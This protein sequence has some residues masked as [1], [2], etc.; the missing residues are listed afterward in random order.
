MGALGTGVSNLIDISKR[1]DPNG[2]VA[3]IIEMLSQV[4]SVMTDMGWM[5]GNLPTGHVITQR[6]SLPGNTWRAF[7]QGVSSTKSTTSQVTEQIGM[8]ESWSEADVDL[9]NLN[10]NAAAFRLSEARPHIESMSQ[11]MAS[12]IFYGNLATEPNSFTGI[13]P[14]YNSL[15]AG[16][17]QNVLDGGGTDSDNTSIYLCVW[18][19]ET[20]YGIY[21]KGSQAG[22]I[23]EDLGLVT[24]TDAEGIGNARMRAYQD[25]FQWKA[26]LAL[27]DWRY[28]ARICNLDVSNLLTKAGAADLVELMISAM[29]V[30]PNLMAGS[31]VFYMNRTAKK[32]LDIQRRTD[33]GAGGQLNY[34]VVDGKPV[35]DFRGVPVRIV[36]KIVNNETRVV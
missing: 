33:V 27:K 3:R 35:F 32:C 15:S 2:S 9:A 8:L 4:N 23:H 30:I 28:V 12:T 26:G 21:P 7:N 17:A 11:E 31:P 5:E 13:A 6:T 34:S 16:N 10:A 25:R 22:L 20:V 36:D 14:R 18:S 1:L 24:I 29:A 19:E